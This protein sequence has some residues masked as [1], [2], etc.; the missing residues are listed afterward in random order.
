M[1]HDAPDPELVPE[2][3]VRELETFFKVPDD[4]HFLVGGRLLQ[5]G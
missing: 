5:E 3:F 1:E 2:D 4:D